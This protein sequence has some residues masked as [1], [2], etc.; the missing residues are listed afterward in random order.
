VASDVAGIPLVVRDGENGLLVPPGDPEALAAA[1]L[2]LLD[3]PDLRRSLRAKAQERMT[4]SHSWP[5]IAKRILSVYESA[6]KEHRA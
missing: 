4:E 6:V 3:K 1:I 5:A 2:E